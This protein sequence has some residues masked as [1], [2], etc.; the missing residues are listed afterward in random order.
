[1]LSSGLLVVHD[2][3][4]S[5]Q[6][7]E[8]ELSSW[9]Q[10]VSPLFNVGNLDVESWRDDTTLV[11]STVQL[12]DNLTRSVVIDVLKLTNVTCLY[13]SNRTNQ[14]LKSRVKEEKRC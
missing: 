10:V 2:T 3:S 12:N 1:M 5:G 14:C 9:Q 7:N 8:T 13:V 6:D 4:G 11:Q